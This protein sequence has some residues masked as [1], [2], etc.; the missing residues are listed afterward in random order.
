MRWLYDLAAVLTCAVALSA[1]G[2]TSPNPSAPTPPSGGGTVTVT[3]V[4]VS[5]PSTTGSSFQLTANAK[6]SDNTTKDVTSA[7]TWQSSNSQLA[8]ISSS[9]VVTVH[10]TG[11]V[12]LQA[13]YQGVS[14]FMHA[15]VALAKTFTLSGVVTEAAPSAK[16]VAGARVQIIVGS[17]TLTDDKGAYSISGLAPGR[18]LVEI[19]K[20]GYQTL[21]TDTTIVDRDVQL[22]PTVFP[23]PP[24]NSDG[25]TATARCNDGSWS[26]AQTRA[27][28]CVANGGIAYGVCPGPL[29]TQ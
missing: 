15:S 17:F 1:C 27:D 28:A 25:A 12:D 4:T 23:S 16:P 8:T 2:S 18:I 29:C 24:K 10:G 3:A 11:E 13:T 9:G 7:A 5:A 6:M 19:S 22:S 26:W 21:E 20:D 14:G